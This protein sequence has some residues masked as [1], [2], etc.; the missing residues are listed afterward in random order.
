MTLKGFTIS[1]A[2]K[3]KERGKHFSIEY[4]TEYIYYPFF[5][6]YL[7]AYLHYC[8]T[9][10]KIDYPQPFS[11]TETQSK[12]KRY[13]RC[14]GFLIL[15]EPTGEP[16]VYCLLKELFFFQVHQSLYLTSL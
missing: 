3:K 6:K 2:G 8:K 7:A 11:I 16:I 12:M 4:V 15:L 13:L 1:H 14:F 5:L 9:D 10:V